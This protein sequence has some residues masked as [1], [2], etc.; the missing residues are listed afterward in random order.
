MRSF[1]G[2]HSR[3]YSTSS[4][5]GVVVSATELEKNTLK[6]VQLRFLG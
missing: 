3:R 1:L 5:P 6:R 2:N 4:I